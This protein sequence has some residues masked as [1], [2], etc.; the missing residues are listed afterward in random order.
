VGGTHLGPALA[1]VER[2]VLAR[3]SGEAFAELAPQEVIGFVRALALAGV[4]AEP[5]DADLARPSGTLVA[6][7]LDLRPVRA[8]AVDLDVVRVELVPLG[9]TTREMLR[10]RA[11]GVLPPAPA[12]RQRCRE[13]LRRENVLFAWSRRAWASRDALRAPS[14]RSVL[15]PVVFA[16]DSAERWDLNGRTT[17][18][19]EDLSRWLFA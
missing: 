7:G 8:G 19:D 11:W 4:A 1:T 6:R 14:V 3:R 18:R 15:R 13:F 10:R 16:R 2:V 5:S 17:A 12:D 9:R